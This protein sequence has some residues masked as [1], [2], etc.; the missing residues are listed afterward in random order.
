MLLQ[1][2]PSECDRFWF[3]AECLPGFVDLVPEL[4]TAGTFD[5][6]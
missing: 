6:V 4:L 2:D 5:R 1:A 3:P